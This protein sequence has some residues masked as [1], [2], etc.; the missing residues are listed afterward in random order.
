MKSEAAAAVLSLALF[1]GAAFALLTLP[2]ELGAAGERDRPDA[3][4]S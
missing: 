3:A 4:A 1:T 2:F